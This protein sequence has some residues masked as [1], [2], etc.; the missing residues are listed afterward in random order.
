MSLPKFEDE[1]FLAFVD[2]S[3]FKKLMEKNRTGAFKTL[4][5]FYKNGYHILKKHKK[6]NGLFISDCGIL[7]V[8]DENQDNDKK[9]SFLLKVV[10]EINKRMLNEG[11]LLTTTI[12]YGYFKYDDRLEFKGIE[13]NLIYGNAYLDAYLDNEKGKKKIRPG[14]CRIL[15]KTLL[16]PINIENTSNNFKFLEKCHSHYYYY[17]W[18]LGD[19]AGR[20]D[21]KQE[22]NH[23]YESHDESRYDKIKEIMKNFIDD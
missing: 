1:T 12:A 10:K 3:G 18:M 13:K 20:D 22:Y 4:D 15:I 7:Y 2:L 11:N 19:L 17:Y 9:L 6:V 16:Y 23:A 14:E 5:T 21:F 8:N